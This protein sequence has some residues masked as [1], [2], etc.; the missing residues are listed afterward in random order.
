MWP[1]K[2]TIPLTALA[3]HNIWFHFNPGWRNHLWESFPCHSLMCVS[4]YFCVVDCIHLLW[5]QSF[6]LF[7]SLPCWWIHVWW[8]FDDCKRIYQFKK[9]KKKEQNSNWLKLNFLIFKC[10]LVFA[11]LQFIYFFRGGDCSWVNAWFPRL[12]TLVSWVFPFLL[13]CLCFVLMGEKNGFR[14]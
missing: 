9:K 4:G 11:V 10:F 13:S 14:T 5:K 7:L 8:N 12:Q 2:A 1:Q 6:S 3:W